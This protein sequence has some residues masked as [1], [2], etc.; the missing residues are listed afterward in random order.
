MPLIRTWTEITPEQA[1]AEKLNLAR[2]LHITAPR[3]EEGE[4]CPWPWEPQQLVGAPL[5]QYHCG[6][7]GAMV[8]A[9]VPHLDYSSEERRL[10]DENFAEVFEWCGPSKMRFGDVGGRM[11][12]VGLTIRQPVAEKVIALFGDTVVRDG[13]GIFTVRRA[14]S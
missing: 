1:T 5:G 9:G 13:Y 2:D 14:E 12:I 11:E 3:S 4:R 8:L 10:T 6:Y 7:C